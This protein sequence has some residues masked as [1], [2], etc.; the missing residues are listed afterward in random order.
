[1]TH[2]SRGRTTISARLT[3][4][5]AACLPACLSICLANS[6]GTTIVGI[7]RRSSDASEHQYKLSPGFAVLPD[8]VR[9]CSIDV[10]FFLL[11]VK[12]PTRVVTVRWV[13]PGHRWEPRSVVYLL[14]E[15][16]RQFR[17]YLIDSV[18]DSS[19][20][21]VVW[22]LHDILGH[23]KHRQ[24]KIQQHRDLLFCCVRGHCDSSH[25]LFDVC[26]VT[27]HFVDSSTCTDHSS[28]AIG[29]GWGEG[30]RPQ[31]MSLVPTV[32]HTGQE[33]GGELCETFKLWSFPQS[34][35][36]NNVCKPVQLLGSKPP[37]NENSWRS[38]LLTSHF[39]RTV[40]TRECTE[41]PGDASVQRWGPP[42]L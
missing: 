13:I 3:K 24:K 37:P 39:S 33:S 8:T 17:S 31:N 18:C 22:R 11:S 38:R 7:G 32:K 6:Q 42:F 34:K 5:T 16:D 10:S 30:A 12:P 27:V 2:R 41:I 40:T 20:A 29:M 36:L 15:A 25:N 4:N 28:G 26:G 9:W 21:S 23:R 19:T 1:M 14:P 35:S